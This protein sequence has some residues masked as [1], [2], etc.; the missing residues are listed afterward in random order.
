MICSASAQYLSLRPARTTPARLP[1]PSLAALPGDRDVVPA[2][3]SLPHRLLGQ[4]SSPPR[5]APSLGSGT[6]DGVPRPVPQGLPYGN[7]PAPASTLPL[8]C[9]IAIQLQPLARARDT[10]FLPSSTLHDSSKPL[11][12]TSSSE[13]R[14]PAS[15]SQRR[16]GSGDQPGVG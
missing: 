15:S 3:P 2:K 16:P 4:P 7:T 5:R 10:T 6:V 9:H 13:H 1:R 11:D 8:L 14:V 12:S